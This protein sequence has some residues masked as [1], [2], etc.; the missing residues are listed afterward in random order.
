MRVFKDGFAAVAN[1]EAWG[2][3]RP[4]GSWLVKPAYEAAKTFNEGFAAIRKALWL[5]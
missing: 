2:Y 4:D 3:I 5:H 1:D